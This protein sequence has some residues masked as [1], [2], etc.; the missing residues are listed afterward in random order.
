M[1]KNEK[2]NKS[3]RTWVFNDF[4]SN[5]PQGK[6]DLIRFIRLSMRDGKLAKAYNNVERT[7][8]SMKS[9]PRW[10]LLENSKRMSTLDFFERVVDLASPLVSLRP[11][12]VKGTVYQVP[13]PIKREKS[14][15]LGLR[16]LLEGARRNS[17]NK[18]A[19][20]EGLSRELFDVY[21]KTGYAYTKRLEVHKLAEENRP[22]SHFRWWYR[23]K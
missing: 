14:R 20:K 16:W 8:F 17:F 1:S 18:C 5:N 13:G 19:F 3:L 4:P 22:F 21:Y 23:T 10:P 11:V 6:E 7:F 12:V 2:R 15:G 9:D